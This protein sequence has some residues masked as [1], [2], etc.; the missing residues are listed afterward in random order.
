MY[1]YIPFYLQVLIQFESIP[2]THI[3]PDPGA[4]QKLN[5]SSAS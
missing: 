4:L 3:L 2:G 5:Q 1:I